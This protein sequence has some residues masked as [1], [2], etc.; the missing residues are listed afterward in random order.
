MT[1]DVYIKKVLFQVPETLKNVPVGSEEYVDIRG[2]ELA[3]VCGQR[4]YQPLDGACFNE[5]HA[6]RLPL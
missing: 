1:S 2:L 3:V 6:Y 5:A 4:L